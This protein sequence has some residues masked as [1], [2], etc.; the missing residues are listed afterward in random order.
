MLFS[1]H[2]FL[3]SKAPFLLSR[4][5][6]KTC[7]KTV[8]EKK[9]KNIITI[10]SLFRWLID[11]PGLLWIAWSV[12]SSN[13]RFNQKQYQQKRRAPAFLF[14]CAHPPS[15][16]KPAGS[17]YCFLNHFGFPYVVAQS[18][19]NNQYRIRRIQSLI[20]ED[21]L[22]CLLFCELYACHCVCTYSFQNWIIPYTYCFPYELPT[23]LFYSLAQPV[24]SLLLFS[25]LHRHL[26]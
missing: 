16:K 10:F 9:G 6:F 18:R 5:G 19:A 24:F 4:P 25:Q 22:A 23:R 11:L 26:S 8:S 2:Q 20:A 13:L 1:H 17:C 14:L 21:K 15:Q 7:Y 3:I 12:T